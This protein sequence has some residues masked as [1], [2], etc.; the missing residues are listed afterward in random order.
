[1]LIE[2]PAERAYRDPVAPTGW[3]ADPA[4]WLRWV[5]IRRLRRLLDQH[6]PDPIMLIE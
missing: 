3:S 5:S 2:Q 6:E 4:C 1:M